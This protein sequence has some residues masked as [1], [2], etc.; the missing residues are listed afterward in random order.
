MVNVLAIQLQVFSSIQMCIYARCVLRTLTAV[1]VTL[2]IQEV[3]VSVLMCRLIH[4]TVKT[5]D[6]VVGVGKTH[7]LL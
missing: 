1:C 6:H 4:L 7:W 5:C 2:A 3:T